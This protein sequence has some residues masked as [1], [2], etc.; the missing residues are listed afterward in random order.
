MQEVVKSVSL[1]LS[2]QRC[3]FALVKG[4]GGRELSGTLA[5]ESSLRVML[6]P[7]ALRLGQCPPPPRWGRLAA[8]RS[9]SSA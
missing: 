7:E 1:G 4:N 5:E 2:S 9:G 3:A 8:E 6:G